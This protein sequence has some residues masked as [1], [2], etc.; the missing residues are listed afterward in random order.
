[1]GRVPYRGGGLAPLGVGLLQLE[2]QENPL[3]PGSVSV[4][5]SG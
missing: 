4:L 1:M 5:Y 2:H 3:G